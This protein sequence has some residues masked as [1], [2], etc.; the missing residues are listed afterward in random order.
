MPTLD[1]LRG[2]LL[3]RE[4][5]AV[6]PDPVLRRLEM[7]RQQAA[8]VD[9]VTPTHP[10]R[11]RL[12]VLVAAAA[13]VAVAAIVGPSLLGSRGSS[14]EAA[15][16]LLQ[17]AHSAGQQPGGWPDV[18]YW[19][20][21]ST[22][23]RDGKTYTREIWISHHGTSVLRDPGVAPGVLALGPGIFPAGGSAFTW[24]QLYALPTDPTALAATLRSGIHGAGKDDDSELFVI[25]GDLLR[26]SPA[27]PALRQALYEVA[28]SVPGVTADGVVTDR[29][30]RRG[31]G[32]TRDGQQYVIDPHT[33]Q[34]LQEQDQGWVST[35]ESQGPATSAPAADR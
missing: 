6:D 21:V 5:L 1:D 34:L 23:Q 7:R 12:A 35:Y 9:G 24:D 27:P 26:E 19:H 25:V 29:D 16:V 22:Y 18:P 8:P 17:A 11:R 10:R 2:A 13:L 14:A 30:D 32:V 4:E 3:D 28:A 15:T 33:G 20:S 31:N